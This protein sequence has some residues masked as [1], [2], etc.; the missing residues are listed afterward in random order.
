M[1]FPCILIALLFANAL[2]YDSWPGNNAV[3]VADINNEFGPNLSGL[4]YLVS[5]P[6]YMD[7]VKNDPSMLYRLIFNGK[8]WVSDLNNFWSSGKQLFYPDG[9]GSPDSED[10]TVDDLGN[11]YACSERNNGDK[12]TA[13][14]SILR[15]EAASLSKDIS[16]IASIEWNLSK[17]F[18]NIDSNSAF[19]GVAWIPDQFL[20]AHNFTDSFL[21]IPYNPSHY[22]DH[23][24]GIFFIAVEADGNVYAY[25]LSN[26][27]SFQ[28]IGK[29]SSG[30]TAIMSVQFDQQSGYLW[31]LCDSNC[32]GRQHVLT[33]DPST[34]TF[35]EIAAFSRPS[36]MPNT[37]LEGFTIQPYTSEECLNNGNMTLVYWSDDDCLDGHA[38]RQ[39]T[40]PCY[41]FL[42]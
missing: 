42:L 18:P 39:G 4:K 30:E 1:I 23:G 8:V 35:K 5:S 41:D 27:G 40:I 33:I 13:R 29:Y 38:I 11:V 3:V 17:D 25:V 10:I 6:D 9:K 36:T 2:G 37:N 12:D 22:P 24:N 19:E 28:Q 32:N 14:P 31:T 7:A 26:D 20:V 34:G 16:L 21:R 15:Y